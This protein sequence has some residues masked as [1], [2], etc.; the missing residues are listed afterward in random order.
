MPCSCS[1]AALWPACR[2]LVAAHRDD[3]QPVFS[4]KRNQPRKIGG[5]D[6][7]AVG[8]EFHGCEVRAAERHVHQ[9]D[10]VMVRNHRDRQMRRAT[11]PSSAIGSACPDG[12]SRKRLKTADV[13]DRQFV[14]HRKRERDAGDDACEQA[15]VLIDVIA[16]IA[17]E[18]GREH[19]IVAATEADRIAIGGCFGN[20]ARGDAPPAPPPWFSTITSWFSVRA[21]AGTNTWATV[22]VWAPG[23]C[24]TSLSARAVSPLAQ[25]GRIDSGSA[26]AASPASPCKSIVDAKPI[27]YLPCVAGL[28]AFSLV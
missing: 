10:T 15:E 5:D 22:S 2:A 11:H 4:R 16:R 18:Q 13:G 21:S 7:D 6:V 27:P 19:Q 28:D 26:L 12:A 14:A 23:S 9:I 20:H 1:V 25:A 24:A 8:D 3:A 17:V